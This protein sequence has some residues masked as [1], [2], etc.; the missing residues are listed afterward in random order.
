MQSLVRLLK[1]GAALAAV[2]GLFLLVQVVHQLRHQELQ[3][4]DEEKNEGPRRAHHGVVTL[5]GEAVEEYGIATAVARAGTWRARIPLSGRVVPNAGATMEIR[6]PF[7]GVLRAANKISWPEPGRSLSKGETVGY[8]EVRVSPQERLDLQVKLNEARLKQQAADEIVKIHQNRVE[9][10]QKVTASVSQRELDIA[11][12][13]L[14]EARAQAGIARA[15]VELWQKALTAVEQGERPGTIWRE[16]LLAPGQGEVTELLARPGSAVEA[17]AVLM[18]AVD[19]RR[20]LLTLDFPRE[21]IG[22]GPPP[23]LAVRLAGPSSRGDSH[24]AATESR[25][26]TLV[27]IAPQSDELLQRVSYW[28]VV[29]PSATPEQIPWRPG[30]FVQGEI[31]SPTA[32]PQSAVE[33]PRAA[34]LFHQGAAFV[35]VQIKPG[36]FQRRPVQVLGYEENHCTLASGVKAGETVVREQAQLLL[37]EEFRTSGDGD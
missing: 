16:A 29:S 17:G 35:Y 24:T 1:W 19:F 21:A 2:A 7:A 27:G 28:Y 12:V 6:A 10:L 30:L 9:R 18:R 4:E 31:E 3:R 32:S 33:V 8:L 15:T 37:S 11:V 26:A 20:I 13:T 5:D 34:I 36:V 25:S 14:T 22:T 23:R